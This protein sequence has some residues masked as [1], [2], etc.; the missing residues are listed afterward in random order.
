MFHDRHVDFLRE[1]PFLPGLRWFEEKLQRPQRRAGVPVALYVVGLTINQ[2][3]GD[4]FDA[5]FFD[6]PAGVGEDGVEWEVF[7]E[8]PANAL[9]VEPQ[10]RLIL[11]TCGRD[12]QRAAG[13]VFT[14]RANQ[15]IDTYFRKLNVC[16]NVKPQ[17]AA[18]RRNCQ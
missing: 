6:A 18:S 1:A 13:V 16:S 3:D 5:R 8:F 12:C 2:V 11:E 10:H 7:G 9:F 15:L 14:R 17:V 4:E